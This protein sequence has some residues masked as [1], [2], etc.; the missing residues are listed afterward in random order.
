MAI[1]VHAKVEA[2]YLGG[3]SRDQP[4]SGIGQVPYSSSGMLQFAMVTEGEQQNW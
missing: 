2:K 1:I 3:V 4:H